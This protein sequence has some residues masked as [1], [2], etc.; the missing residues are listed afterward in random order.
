M[1][2]RY[3]REV[4]EIFNDFSKLTKKAD[5]VE[6]LKV[7]GERTP[8]FKDVIRGIFDE[9][10]KFVLPEGKPPYSPNRPESTPSSL[11]RLHRQFGDYVEGARNQ[12]QP[13]FKIERSFI[14]LLESVHAEDALIVVDMINKKSPVKS[15]TKKLVQEASPS[16]LPSA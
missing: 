1:I 3:E 11:R 13:K 6:F 2:N 8:A 9:R 5:K 15:L 14:Q 10:L 16:M 7:E 4:F 12:S